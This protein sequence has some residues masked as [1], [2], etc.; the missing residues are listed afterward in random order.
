LWALSPLRARNNKQGVGK[1][2][3]PE[4]V[5]LKDRVL[6]ARQKAFAR[7]IVQETCAFDNV[8]YEVCNEPAG[9]LPKH[10]SVGE[11]DAWLKEMAGVVRDELK[12]HGGKHLVFGTQAFDVGKLRQE[13]GATVSGTT[14]DAANIHPHPYLVGRDRAHH[15]GD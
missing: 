8:Y 9:G 1:G 10:V 12:T 2:E 11:V 14:W 13:L 7:K 15:M 6:V 3:W 4:F 5:S